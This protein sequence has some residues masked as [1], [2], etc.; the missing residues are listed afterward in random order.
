MFG[1]T[2]AAAC[3]FA[4]DN[5]MTLD[6]L[7]PDASAQMAIALRVCTT[8]TGMLGVMTQP[9][10]PGFADAVAADD[11]AW[12]RRTLWSGTL[13]VAVLA[14]TGSALIIAF[15]A[16]VLRWW[17][18]QDLHITTA[19]LWVMAA[20][21]VMTT[22]CHI[23]GLLLNATLRL[24]PQIFILSVAATTG[25]VLKYFAARQFGVIGILSVSPVLWSCFVVPAYFWLAW[26]WIAKP[27]QT[28]MANDFGT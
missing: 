14:V 4:F 17:L 16:P 6:W 3:A 2:I 27:N 18:R 11:R 26:R 13:G 1:I 8:A 23:P 10:W 21:I 28:T 24:R 19:L 22:L 25:F 5:L 12:V 20:W 7:G 15:G 9:F